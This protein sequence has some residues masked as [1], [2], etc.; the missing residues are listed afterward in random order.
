MMAA[1]VD[2][3]VIPVNPCSRV[4]LPKIPPRVVEPMEPAAVL[5]LAE[6]IAP[7]YRVG[8]ALAA[9]AGLRFGEATGLTVPRVNFLRRRVQVL[10]QVQNGAHAPL[11]TDA[12]K[13]VVPVGEWVLQ[14]ITAHLQRYGAG[15]AQVVM[16]NAAGG[17]SAGAR[18][19]TYGV[20][21]WLRPDC[22]RVPGF[23]TCATS[24]PRR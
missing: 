22:R 12:S 15:P 3:G 23:T 8:V 18:S 11:K 14:E 5:A 9:G 13:R 6:A 7:R 24:T 2:D 1:A 17:S 4:K 16:S 20:R 10:E 21:R 19:A